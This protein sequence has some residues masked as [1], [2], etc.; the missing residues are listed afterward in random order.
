MGATRIEIRESDPRW[1]AAIAILERHLAYANEHSPPESV[2]A[3]DVDGLCAPEVTFWL[4]FEGD[5]A[6]GC[7]ALKAIEDLPGEACGHG[8]I[9]SMHVLAAHRGKGHGKRLVAFVLDEARS[10]G[11]GRVS[12]E[13]GSMRAYASARGVYG[14]FGFV[15]CQPFGGYRDDPLSTCMTLRLGAARGP[16]PG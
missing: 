6:V 1:P 5:A 15:V 4:L 11:Y 13:T 14:G 10:R 2:H 8:E 16:Q 7:V 3:L 9:K 12:L